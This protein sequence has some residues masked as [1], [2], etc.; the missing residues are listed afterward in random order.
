MAMASA[1]LGVDVGF[2]AT[3]K[4][5][6]LAWRLDGVGGTS[7]TG[8]TWASRAAALPSNVLF[9]VVALDAP[10]VPVGEG[11]PR[12]S[13]EAAFYR[14]EFWNRC[15]PGMSHHGRGLDLRNAGRDAAE[16]FSKVARPGVIVQGG[17]VPGVPLVE[18]FPNTFLGVLLPIDAYEG[19]GKLPKG[20]VRSDWLYESAVVN[21]VFQMLIDHLGWNE[22][23]TLQL[24]LRERDHDLRSALVC[25]LTAGFAA[26]GT[27]TIVGDEDGGWF[28]LPPFDLWSPWARLALE[29]TIIQARRRG[30]QRLDALVG[31]GHFSTAGSSAKARL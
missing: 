16:Q 6:G 24:M 2:S 7:L 26:A 20:K 22:P 14:G 13:C 12:Q 30:Y 10:L 28:C 5:T 23:T 19:C 1:L 15:R 25:L 29:L 9:D 18:A 8:T 31:D 17:V 11:I 21:G 3:A 4:S 27:A